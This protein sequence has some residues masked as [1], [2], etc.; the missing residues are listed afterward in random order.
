MSK[1][2]ALEVNSEI[3]NLL[4]E[5]SISIHDGVGY[6]LMLYYGISP[7]YIPEQLEKKVLAAGIVTK[8]Y[9]SDTIKWL[10]PLFE[11][12]ETGFEW[13]GEWMD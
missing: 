4:K 9:S 11:E 13:I 10:L 7:S 1:K 12:Q 2:I 5:K 8:D 3:K 6:L